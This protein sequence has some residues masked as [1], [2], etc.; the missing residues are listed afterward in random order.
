MTARRPTLT[1]A[2]IGAAVALGA[3]E[4]ENHF[5]NATGPLINDGDA[6]EAVAIIHESPDGEVID[7]TAEGAAFELTLDEAEHAFRS[8]FDY[9]DTHV[10]ID[11]GFSVAEREIVF[12]DDPFLEDDLVTERALDFEED[13]DRIFLRDL[14]AGID[15]DG[16]GIRETAEFR[17]VLVRE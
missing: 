2:L 10:D 8:S 4:G 12:S 7:L 17:V 9:L 1:L 11:G 3:C 5:A 14:D 6:F 15:L 13:G 16:D